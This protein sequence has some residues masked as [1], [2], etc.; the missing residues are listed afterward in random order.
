MTDQ[1]PKT[2][3]QTT[4]RFHIP[5]TI[6]GEAATALTEMYGLLSQAPEST[7][8][9][10][11]SD[12]DER[13]TLAKQGFE[14]LS[15]AT[16]QR[17]QIETI[18]DVIGGVPVLRIRPPDYAPSPVRLIYTHGGAYTMFSAETPL[19][20]PAL[21]AVESG[22]EV[23]SIDYTLAPQLRWQ[24]VTDQ[25]LAVWRALLADGMD[26]ERTGLFGDS[27]GGGLAA[28]SVLKMRDAGLPLPGAL[29]LV[30]P[31]SD[32]TATGD[33]VTTLADFDPILT[34]EVLSWSAAAYADATDQTHPYVSPVYG[35]YSKPFP[36][37][38]IQVGTREIF[39][40]HAVRHYQA[41]RF[42]GHDAVLDVYEGMPHVHQAMLPFS[43]ESM[44]ATLRASEFL[45]R[46]LKV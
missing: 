24:G 22:C 27:A 10:S 7:P 2:S 14:P 36:P 6:S 40:S 46:H 44:T 19:M 20:L 31:W 45:A 39:L 32:I 37:T 23:I 13:N 28:G 18:K 42:G 5:E 15:Q 33:S 41:I 4:R 8:P 16:A 21:M 30:S 35:D 34:S 38:L 25:V 9:V 26:S 11:L 17:L 29:Y 1:P 3:R 12:W 43:P